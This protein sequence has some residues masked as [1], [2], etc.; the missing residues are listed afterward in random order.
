[1]IGIALGDIAIVLAAH[2]DRAG[3]KPNATLL[4]HRDAL[5]ATGEF[6]CVTAGVL[7]AKPIGY[8]RRCPMA[9]NSRMHWRPRSAHRRAT[10]RFFQCSCLTGTSPAR[11][12]PERVATADLTQMCTILPP[13][14]LDRRLPGLMLCEALDAAVRAGVDPNAARLLIVGHGSRADPASAHATRRAAAA[15]M[16]L[17]RFSEVATAF[18]EEPAFLEDALT[19][20]RS[21]RSCRVLF[22]GGCARGRRCA[23]SDCV[24]RRECH[25]CRIDRLLRRDRAPRRR[26]RAPGGGRV[27]G[28][29]QRKLRSAMQF[30]QRGLPDGS[31]A[32][33]SFVGDDQEGG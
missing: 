18:L 22:R 21:P 29:S 1:M 28:V 17:T 2:G 12:C 32:D 23:A 7:R 9:S 33:L 20:A 26:L 15:I 27:N 3:E 11:C 24:N 25:L 10:S 19:T 5:G 14:G 8:R 6:R 31:A 4:R 16:G 13:L 30:R